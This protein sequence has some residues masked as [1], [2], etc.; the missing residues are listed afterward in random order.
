M[1]YHGWMSF[2]GTEIFSAPRTVKYAR[3][4][5]PALNL[6]DCEDCPDLAAAMGEDEYRSPLLDQPDWFDPNN[7]D[8]WGFA[9]FYPL[10]IQGLS[11]STRTVPVID[12]TQDGGVVGRTRHGVREIRVSG[13]LVAADRCALDVGMEWLKKALDGN[14]CATCDGNDLCI[15][16]CCPEVTPGAVDPDSEPV[17]RDVPLNIGWS[18]SSGTWV[19]GRFRP[20]VVPSSAAGPTLDPPCDDVTYQWRL[21]PAPGVVVRLALVDETGEPVT[22]TTVDLTDGGTFTLTAPSGSGPVYPTIWVINGD[23]VT[24][25]SLSVTYREPA[26]TGFCV[27]D[28]VRTFR[29]VTVVDGPRIVEEYDTG[30]EAA[31]VR[32]EWLMVAAVPWAHQILPTEYTVVD[33][34]GGLNPG[35]Y[36]P[37]PGYHFT[38]VEVPVDDCPDDSGGDLLPINDPD[39]PMPPAPPRPPRPDDCLDDGILRYVR[40]AVGIPG[41]LLAPWQEGVPVIELTV[42]TSQAVRQARIRFY[43]N[44]LGRD[45]LDQLEPCAFCGEFIVSY[46]PGNSTLTIDGM[47]ERATVTL[48]GDVQRDA[49]HLLYGTDGGPMT[50]PLLT[51]GLPYVMTVDTA[52]TSTEVLTT[53][54]QLVVRS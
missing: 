37:G 51:C 33:T 10:S 17:T 23:E 5:A 28:Y 52:P 19:N 44:P 43:P 12:S 46:I 53:S 45:R 3:E 34:G 22:E 42:N 36:D 15:L 24:T 21:R 47:T 9:G 1:P 14:G 54:M 41:D 7:P 26:D 11:D 48:P 31:A 2:G 27:D 32:V 18:E 13:L 50:W 8:T 4:I 35:D 16:S 29:E 38:D 30:C 40:R 49:T 25:V 20:A 39:C 6:T